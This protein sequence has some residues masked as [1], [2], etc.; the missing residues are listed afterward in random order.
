MP[1]PYNQKKQETDL[2]IREQ[3]SQ[4]QTK[5]KSS[6]TKQR[7]SSASKSNNRSKW[8]AIFT[9]I[10]SPY[11]EMFSWINSFSL[12]FIQRDAPSAFFTSLPVQSILAVID[13]LAPEKVIRNVRDKA[14]PFLYPGSNVGVLLT[15]GFSATAQEMEP[16]GKYIHEQLGYTT[17]GVLLKGHGTS[18]ADLAQTDMIDW[19]HSIYDGYTFLKQTCDRIYLVAHSMGATLSLLLAANEEVDGIVAMCTPIKVRYFMQD[20]LFLVADLLKY[21]PRRKEEIEMMDKYGLINYRVS[22]LKGVEHLLDLLEVA[23]EEIKNVTAPLLTITA[24]KDERVP[25]D[26]AERIHRLVKSSVKKDYVAQDSPHTILFGPEQEL[27]MNKTIEF[28]E[29]LERE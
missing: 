13:N 6:P 3:V 19:Y 10:L 9:E 5:L 26:N 27:I 16:L 4:E 23:R 20:Y 25:L 8:K 28:L 2:S 29:F 18:P 15:H 12:N 14:A 11:K 1:N 22:A 7:P 21:F 24:G 17:Y